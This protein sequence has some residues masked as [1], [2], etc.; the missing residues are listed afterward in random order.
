M[1]VAKRHWMDRL[2]APVAPLWT[3]RRQRARLASDLL[4]RHYE[5]AAPGRRTQ[6]WYRVNTD[7]NTANAYWGGLAYTR[8]AARDLV[9]NNPY[10]A[11]ALNTIVDHAIGTGITA[12]PMPDNEAAA[13]RWKAWA[14]STACDADGRHDLVGLEKLAFRTIVESGEVLVRRRVR[15]PDDGLPIPLQ[16]QVLEPDFL[17][18]AK[19]VPA[20]PNGGTIVQGVEFD[21]LGKPAAYWLF[22]EHPG[23][24]RLTSAVS[25]RV[26]ASEIRHVFKAGRPGQARAASWFAPV[27]LRFKDFDELEDATLMKQK[28]AAC[29]AVLTSDVDGAG[30]PLGT[31]STSDPTIETLE[32]GMIANIP[33]GR[34]VSVINP[35]TTTEYPE[36]AATV[37]R[38]IATGLGVTY[39]DLTGDYR[40]M[41]FS[42]A[43]MSR[44]RHWARVEDW[45]WHLLIPQLLDPVWRWA[46]ELAALEGTV[47]A[48]LPAAHWSAPPMPMIEPD[49]EGLAHMRNVRAGITSLA[50]VIRERGYDPIELFDEMAS[51]N[52]ELDARGIVLDSD[53]RRMTQAGQVQGT[54]LAGLPAVDPK[55]P[56]AKD[57]E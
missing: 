43:R 8:A 29:L 51:V 47:Q 35:P 50:E 42:A 54:P 52:K 33:A 27:L 2:T 22:R 6:G 40:N 4:E 25:S 55:P 28:V 7:A 53:P 9:R 19:D 10:A 48:P 45:R 24:S 14:E 16:I 23:S 32:P 56:S 3:L 18:T 34:S 31:V 11:S 36:Y 5:A 57:D 20:L 37:L 44:L 30:T 17:D 13:A 1:S 21:V 12:K 39:E 26:P 15:R 49:K 38:A 41:P 46:M